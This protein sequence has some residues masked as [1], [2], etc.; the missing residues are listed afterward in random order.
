MKSMDSKQDKTEYIY[1]VKCRKKV[2]IKNPK[3][4]T[5]KSERLALTGVCPYC[6]T[7]CYQITSG[8]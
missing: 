1:C 3:T 6:G 8:V 4:I 7:N 2:P 5:M